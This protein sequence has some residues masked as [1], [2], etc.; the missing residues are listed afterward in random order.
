VA[1]YR[2]ASQGPAGFQ[3]EVAV[4][5]NGTQAISDWRIVIALPYDQ[6]FS[7]SN[8]SGFFSN[9]ILL[10]SPGPGANPVRPGGTLRVFFVAEG[11]QTVPEACAFNQTICS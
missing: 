8:A 7:F 6:V 1:R 3:G 5:N 11:T 10:L 9:G 2:I 4:T